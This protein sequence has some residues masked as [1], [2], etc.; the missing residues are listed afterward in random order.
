MPNSTLTLRRKIAKNFCKTVLWVDDE[1]KPNAAG[2]AE[3][4]RFVDFFYPIAQEFNREGVICQLREFP[5]IDGENDPYAPANDEVTTSTEL[6]KITDILILDWQLGAE[7]PRHSSSILKSL[8]SGG[9]TRFIV[10]L[11]KEK[12]LTESFEKEFGDSFD[13]TESGWYRN[14]TDQF[15]LLLKKD[16]FNNKD[17]GKALLE[18]IYEEVSLAYPDYLHWGAM[19]IA[20]RIKAFSPN[21]LKNLPSDTDL[22]VLVERTHSAE[23]IGHAIFENLLEDLKETI[24]PSAIE[25]LQQPSLNASE[26]PKG[27]EYFAL[28]DANIATLSDAALSKQQRQINENIIAKLR[29][30]LHLTSPTITPVEKK[31][32]KAFAKLFDPDNQLNCVQRFK[33]SLDKLADFS[34]VI[35]GVPSDSAYIKRG[36]VF[37]SEA[38]EDADKIWVCISEGCDCARAANLLFLGGAVSDKP[39]P[40]PGA[41]FLRFDQKQYIFFPAAENL[42]SKSIAAE[43]RRLTGFR[44]VGVLREVTL[45]RLVSRF[46]GQTTRVGI[47]QPRFIREVRSEN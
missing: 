28:V 8:V 2:E 13:K 35:S 10:I 15:V 21:W 17:S 5:Q 34:E 4:K 43:P 22:A 20:S 46:W 32:L 3:R 38:A 9:G 6:A 14:A 7:D 40:G 41:T 45:N 39:D 1:I 37:R 16:D 19:E 44:Q 31:A 24:G 47:N 18:K 33:Q 12:D 42:H 27:A 23:D 11:S 36:S 29:D 26:W 30:V 25:C